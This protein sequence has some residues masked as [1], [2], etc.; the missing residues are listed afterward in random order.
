MKGYYADRNLRPLFDQIKLENGLTLKRSIEI[1]FTPDWEYEASLKKGFLGRHRMLADP[2]AAAIRWRG[3]IL[4][5]MATYSPPAL[6]VIIPLLMAYLDH[7]ALLT[8]G[9]ALALAVIMRKTI[10][11]TVRDWMKRANRAIHRWHNRK[12]PGAVMTLSADV[13]TAVMPEC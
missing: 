11:K 3:F 5:R 9:V 7:H 6:A 1:D 12:Y 4:M 13:P 8:I 2:K 10:R